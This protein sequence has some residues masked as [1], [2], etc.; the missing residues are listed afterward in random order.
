M[1]TY[2]SLESSGCIY[3][4]GNEK[5][6]NGEAG[7]SLIGAYRLLNEVGKLNV[8]C[9]ISPEKDL[10]TGA[11]SYAREIAADL[12]VVNSNNESRL[13]GLWNRLTGKYLSKESEISVL[14][15]TA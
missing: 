4:M 9:A 12:I 14:T 13:A 11:L 3:L 7:A 2:I 1:A 6:V 15:V 10:A 5:D 8:Q